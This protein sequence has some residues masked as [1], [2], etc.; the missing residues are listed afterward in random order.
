M[1]SGLPYAHA[2]LHQILSDTTASSF[3]PLTERA[4]N[5]AS[6]HVG[7]RVSGS[8]L[9]QIVHGGLKTLNLYGVQ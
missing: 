4:H 9:T 5:L 2:H 3:N 1:K 8:G 6:E 7:N